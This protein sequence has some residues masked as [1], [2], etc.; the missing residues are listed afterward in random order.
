MSR[1]ATHRDSKLVPR[2]GRTIAPADPVRW[3]DGMP[4]A[5]QHFQESTRRHE[6]VLDYQLELLAPYHYGVVSLVVDPGS[7][8]AGVLNVEVEAVLPD[9][10]IVKKALRNRKLDPAELLKKAGGPRGV[11]QTFDVY[12]AVPN[13]HP[14]SAASGEAPRYRM[15]PSGDRVKDDTTGE[16]ELEVLRLV[17]NAEV[18]VDVEPPRDASWIRLAQLRL[19]GEALARGDYVPPHLV[20]N[21]GTALYELC[22]G[23]VDSLRATANR[24]GERI[25]VLSEN[26]DASLIAESRR[27]LYH[28]TAALPSFEALLYTRRAH[29]FCLYMALCAVTGHLAAL[30]RTP[31]PP[32]PPA[33]DHDDLRGVF[34]EL[35]G[36][37][38]RMVREGIKQSFKPH[39][40]DVDDDARARLGLEGSVFRLEFVSD[41][42]MRAVIL[43]ARVSRSGDLASVKK[44]IAGAIVAPAKK[45]AELRKSRA[46]GVER[47][48]IERKDDL[49]PTSDEVLVELKDL[50]RF[51]VADEPMLIFNPGPGTEESRPVEVV[52][53]V[54]ERPDFT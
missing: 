28:L 15:P 12:L 35:R 20:V 45:A 10:L 49:V 5:P 25:T 46:I 38:E 14:G 8:R 22:C 47:E 17:P 16:G 37:I 2:R 4:L 50:G 9:R 27:Q 32:R 26:T 39:A 21:D 23:L 42:S 54:K 13:E 11:A 43:A 31:V 48:V 40:F 41:W 30:A 7:L 24:L 52:L 33:Y 19:E 34:V 6:R 3:Y 29:P 1:A 51:F 44:W 18:I 36:T 53:H